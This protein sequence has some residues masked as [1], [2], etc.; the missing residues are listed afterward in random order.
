MQKSLLLAEIY[1]PNKLV[2][3]CA[4]QEKSDVGL[5][6]KTGSDKISSINQGI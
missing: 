5:R 2:L 4:I 3:A 6:Y 1:N